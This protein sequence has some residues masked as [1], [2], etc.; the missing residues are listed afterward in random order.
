MQEHE[1]TSEGMPVGSAL[2]KKQ[3]LTNIILG[4][5]VCILSACNK[6][7]PYSERPME[8]L[9]NQGRAALLK[10]DNFEAAK[11]FSEVERQ[12]PYSDW[13]PQAQLMSAY[14]YYLDQ[15][16]EDAL[17]SL[18][19]FLQL[20]PAHKDA[21][22]ALYLQ[23]LCYYERLSPMERDQKITQEGLDVFNE[24]IRR[25]PESKYTRDAKFKIDLLRDN[26]A[27]KEMSV[28]RYYL[29]KK[30]YLAAVNRFKYVVEQ[31]QTT[32][33]IEEAL[34][35]LVECYVAMGL[36]QEARKVA[37]Y[38]G[39][40]FPG[41]T[42]YADTYYLLEGQDFRT[43]AQKDEGKHWLDHVNPWHGRSTPV[44]KEK[45]AKTI[46]DQEGK[47]IPAPHPVETGA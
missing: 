30:N 44:E 38:L 28:G 1:S 13:A 39:Y 46:L 23:G 9:Y 22:Y 31:Y 45:A 20:H 26:L 29:V 2:S 4:A 35:R 43:E 10:G 16:Y 33:H 40:N 24:L 27:A 17:D 11:L 5:C 14:A 25:F 7:T 34:H 42:W 21:P 47:E 8:D 6:E 3:L 41:S 37:A 12:H 36:P 15:K 32:A 19:T 18:E